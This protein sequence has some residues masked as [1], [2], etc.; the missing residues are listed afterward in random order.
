MPSG[1]DHLIINS[2]YEEPRRHWDYNHQR[3]AFELAEGRRP[4][5]YTVAST[6]RRLINDPGVFVQIP[7]VNQIR[8]RVKEWRENGYAGISGITK[9]LLEHWYKTGERTNRL[10]FCQLEAIETLIWLA[11]ASPAEKVG[12]DIPS[13]G[14]DL[15][16]ICSKMA[17]GTGKTIVMAM[18]I[19]WQALNKI[20]YPNKKGFAKDFLIIAPNLTVRSRLSVLFPSGEENY[21]D[22]FNLAPLGLGE[23]LRQAKVV[24]RNW[25]ALAWDTEEKLKKK[26]SVD[27]RGAKSDEAYAREVLGELA[28]SK[29]FIVINDEAHH[30]WRIPAGTKLSRDEKKDAEE[31]TIWI[32]GLDR[33]NRARGIS[34]VYDFSATPFIPSGKNS[35]SENLFGWIVSD[36]GLT[37]AIESG[38]VKTPRVVIRDDGQLAADYRS[39]F[40]H[41][42]NDP[43]VKPS[44]NKKG[45]PES[46]PLPPLVENAYALLGKDWR[47]WAQVWRDAGSKIPPVMISVAN[48]TET[49]ARIKFAFDRCN[50]LIPE[51]CNAEKTLHIDS[52]V[53]EAAET[54]AEEEAGA[55]TKTT[56]E[57]V[58]TEPS[59]KLT[60]KEQAQRLRQTVDTIGRPGELGEQIQH[61]ISV[62]ML[63]EGWDAKTVTH[64]MG[65]RAFSS[66]LLCEQVVGRGL[67]RTTYEVDEQ[68]FFTP[69]YVNIF[70][71]PFAFMPH[72]SPTD[73]KTP[74]S[75]PKQRIQ[76]V[77]EKVEFEIRF[78][79]VVRIESKYKPVLKLD[80]NK[81]APLTLNAY[82]TRE[83]AELAPV[84]DGRHDV[85]RLSEID[86]EQIYSQVRL[87]SSIFRAT[88]DIHKQM[89]G[90]WKGDL[91]ALFTQLVPIVENFIY[92]DKLEISPPM[93][94]LENKRRRVLVRL[95]A[96]TV[97]NHLAPFIQQE[98]VASYELIVDTNKPI[99]STGD[100]KAWDTSKPYDAFKKTHVNLCVYDSRWE[101]TAA[102]HL[103]RSPHVIAWAKNDHLGFEIRYIFNGGEHKYRPDFLVK[104][105]SDEMLVIEIKGE[106]DQKDKVKREAM[107]EWVRA[108]NQHGGF[109]RWYSEPAVSKRPDDIPQILE[110]AMKA[111]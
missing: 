62:G 26:R 60:K 81:V 85:T 102:I 58:E 97:V 110:R 65:L 2:P 86:L 101:K 82:D 31:A 52:K 84:I 30:A 108:V 50:I 66:Q 74:P 92:S 15:G 80:L 94:G 45:A 57:E 91:N 70:G 21:Y 98:N 67:R 68:G 109:G 35:S 90:H 25:H 73:S 46:E 47:E 77:P 64:I 48:Q 79:N 28:N 78:P 83:I 105:A 12:I 75:A 51:L 9:Q 95:N 42:Y 54:Y 49:A 53:L 93:F 14:G 71:V 13:D 106:E 63:T 76:P 38:L 33:L 36:F 1:I 89:H 59:R 11:E 111:K 5:G 69:E 18:L 37:E 7:L 24:I 72:E 40:Y 22:A 8:Q 88:L 34:C 4:S 55:E 56:D 27:K 19:A 61:V 32:G 41:L 16:R 29:N 17:T 103:D 107:R 39:K 3:M 104:L 44:L 87:Q 20:S 23:Q 43:E 99:I 100:M 6:E 10:F 96:S